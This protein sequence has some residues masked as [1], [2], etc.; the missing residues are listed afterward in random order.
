MKI[1][2]QGSCLCAHLPTLYGVVPRTRRRIG[3]K[4][5]DFQVPIQWNLSKMDTIMELISV[6][7]IEV[8]LF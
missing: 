8:S 1:D 7:Y 2:A 5:G 4:S 3:I 6:L